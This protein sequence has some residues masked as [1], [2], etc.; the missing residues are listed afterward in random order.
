MWSPLAGFGRFGVNWALGLKASIDRLIF[1]DFFTRSQRSLGRKKE[2][3][4]A[5]RCMHWRFKALALFEPCPPKWGKV[6]S[7][8]PSVTAKSMHPVKLCAFRLALADGESIWAWAGRTAQTPSGKAW[9]FRNVPIA[10]ACKS[11]CYFRWAH[12]KRGCQ[13]TET[14]EQNW[15]P[16]NAFQLNEL[17]LH[18]LHYFSNALPSQCTAI[19]FQMFSHVLSVYYPFSAHYALLTSCTDNTMHCPTMQYY[20]NALQSQCTPPH[21]ISITLILNALIFI[22]FYCKITLCFTTPLHLCTVFSNAAP[23]Q[24]TVIVPQTHYYSMR[25]HFGA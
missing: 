1:F 12:R 8:M 13:C 5:D 3:R 19:V 2:A 20:P 4:P 16:I 18:I 11:L 21:S 24:C 10:Y 9:Y 25:F 6:P 7:C 14:E 23:F 17:R 22:I 15:T